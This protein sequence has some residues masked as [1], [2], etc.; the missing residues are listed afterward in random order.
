M[1]ATAR[2]DVAPR[3]REIVGAAN[4]I[5][6][7]TELRTY[8]ADGLTSFRVRPAV[9]VLPTSTEEVAACVKVAREARM[10]IVP[11]GSGTGLSGGALPSEDSIV[12]G[13]SRMNK[14]LSVD[15]DGLRMRVQPGVI[16]LDISKY[17]AP[18]G[19]YYAPDPSSQSVGSIGGNV[20]ENSGGAHC[21]KYGFTTNHVTALTL[22]LEDGSVVHVGTEFGDPLGY[23]LVSAI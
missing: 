19:Y 2:P 9:V 1:I 23:D 13:L 5:T 17:I 7:P 4:C 10:P 3:L 16:N 6:E 8:E 22:V 12:I 11:R 15:L 20:A 21:L 18:L 14:I